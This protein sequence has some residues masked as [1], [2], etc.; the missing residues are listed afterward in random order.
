MGS[1][2]RGSDPVSMT[3]IER[4]RQT[5]TQR[6]RE[7]ERQREMKP[8]ARALVAPHRQRRKVLLHTRT[9]S[10]VQVHVTGAQRRQR[11]LLSRGQST[12]RTGP[13]QANV[14]RD[15]GVPH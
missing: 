14:W 8:A 6:E 13:G 10:V 11:V 3:H 15:N 7:T 12:Q 5:H 4:Q 2:D 1:D 9:P